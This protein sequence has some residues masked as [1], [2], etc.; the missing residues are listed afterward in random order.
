MEEY[1]RAPGYLAE[2]HVVA[3]PAD[4]L[5]VSRRVREIAASGGFPP[6]GEAE[7]GIVARELAT[8]I[9]RHAGH[10]FIT[11]RL[12]GSRILI[13]A[14]DDGPGLPDGNAAFADGHTTAGGLGYGLGTVNRLM[15]HVEIASRAGRGTV[16]TAHRSVRRVSP[17]AGGRT[18]SPVEVGVATM[19]K[20]G[21]TE[22][23]D[24][25]VVR[26]WGSSLL[27]GVLDGIG[28]GSLAHA[29]TQKALSYIGSHFDQPFDAVFS[30]IDIA[31]RGT[32]GVVI[33]LARFDW[34]AQTIEFASVGNVEARVFGV[35]PPLNFLARRG[36]LGVNAPGPLVQT[37]PWPPRA[38]L[39]LFSDGVVSHWGET[40]LPNDPEVPASVTAR[41]L[42]SEFNRLTDD[43]TVLVVKPRF[44]A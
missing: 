9:L 10:G 14:R 15:D 27:V 39:V 11:L 20:P 25:Y 12:E 34:S 26:S 42:L 44:Q 18:P 33:A 38:T 23:G 43:A 31:C 6:Q 4:V 32:R 24:G 40:A 7:L 37:F 8:N 3:D 5:I 28:H 19:P 17:V 13:E 21:F 16:V 2:T 22:N 36:I 30:G 41:R 35:D 29:A 1:A